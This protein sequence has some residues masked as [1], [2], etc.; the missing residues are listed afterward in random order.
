LIRSIADALSTY[1]CDRT[2]DRQMPIKKM[3]HVM[4]QA[5]IHPGAIQQ[6]QEG[7]RAN[8]DRRGEG[9]SRLTSSARETAISIMGSV[10]LLVTLW[11]TSPLTAILTIA[12]AHGRE[13]KNTT[14]R[15][16]ALTAGGA[17]ELAAS[18]FDPAPLP[19][20]DTIDA[21]ADITVF[22]RS[23]V[24]AELQRAALRRAW[25]MDPAIRDFK[26]LQENDW[27]FSRSN[28]IPGFGELGPEVDVRQMVARIFGDTPRVEL[29]RSTSSL[30]RHP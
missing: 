6:P 24:P 26:G 29:A 1:R 10:F 30:R 18:A 11:I 4:S 17:P 15:V 9:V 16:A 7:S 27:N 8:I 21:Q 2:H 23:G 13:D 20:L 5:E 19:S 3:E 22:L 28:S 12:L 25:R 14:S